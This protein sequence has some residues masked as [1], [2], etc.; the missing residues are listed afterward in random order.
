MTLNLNKKEELNNNVKN[1]K[2][3]NET[4]VNTIILYSNNTYLQ[5]DA[6]NNL[7][8]NLKDW[9]SKDNVTLLKTQSN[10]MPTAIK[11]WVQHLS[12]P[13]VNDSSPRD[14][15]VAGAKLERPAFDQITALGGDINESVHEWHKFFS[16]LE[17]D[18]NNCDMK[19]TSKGEVNDGIEFAKS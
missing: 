8:S 14:K 11:E 15:A 16:L 13:S 2:T 10:W 3:I 1:D 7:S 5:L 6:M 17:I 12:F 4:Q 9:I 19:A 18:C